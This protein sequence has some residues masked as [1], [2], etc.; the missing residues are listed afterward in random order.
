MSKKALNWMI[1][2]FI[3]NIGITWFVFNIELLLMW[4]NLSVSKDC[5]CKT[6]IT[7]SPHLFSTMRN[8][9][10]AKVARIDPLIIGL[11]N[12]WMKRNV[13]NRAMRRYYTSSIMWLV[14]KLLM[15]ICS[16]VFIGMS[17]SY[18][19][20]HLYSG[21]L[22]YL[23]IFIWAGYSLFYEPFT[24]FYMRLTLF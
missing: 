6:W 16:F 23:L 2:Q 9:Q 20:K 19:Y 7:H 1:Y 4:F 3:W 8:D 11:G 17:Y 14:A 22:G 12:M 21:N 5:R 13:G 24:R 10:V 18:F 15:N